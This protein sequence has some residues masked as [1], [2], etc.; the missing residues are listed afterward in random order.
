MSNDNNVKMAIIFTFLMLI[1]PL[2]SALSVTT[3][4]NGNEEVTVEVRD[5]PD[6]KNIID[7]T[8]SLSPGQ[9]V[10]SASVDLST[11]M[12]THE[13]HSTIDNSTQMFV[14]DPS[15][16]NQQ[17]DF[18]N[19]MDF[20]YRESSVKLVSGGMS[21]DFERTN[22]GFR[23]VSEPVTNGMGWQHGSLIDSSILN[24]GCGSGNDCWGTNMYDSDNDYINDHNS[25]F[26]AKFF[27][28]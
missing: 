1:S 5:A 28:Q 22:A 8:V 14:W 2:A 23:D 26:S 24:D 13:T 21:T 12:A 27:S 3:F 15:V 20:T 4:S 11:S 9:T 16:N 18:S 17:T 6:Y 25:G 7:G 10:T 19:I